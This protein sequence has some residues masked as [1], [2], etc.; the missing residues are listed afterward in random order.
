MFNPNYLYLLGVLFAAPCA[1]SAVVLAGWDFAGMDGAAAAVNATS[2]AANVNSAAITRGAGAGGE[3]IWNNNTNGFNHSSFSFATLD[4]AKSNN[5]YYQWTVSSSSAVISLETL[6]YSV[7]AQ[8]N[9]ANP[10]LLSGTVEYSLDGFSTAGAAIHSFSGV[11][12][13]GWGNIVANQQTADLTAVSSLQNITAGTT[14]TFRFFG[15]NGESW[16]AQGIGGAT[17]NS[18]EVLGTAL[19]PEPGAYA[20]LAALCTLALALLRRRKQ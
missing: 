1:H 12:V 20:V 16:T 8:G 13:S 15:Y 4:A 5:V 9:G 19:V 6:N 10:Q 2:L 11:S 7:Y 18:L 3:A 17:G 14:V